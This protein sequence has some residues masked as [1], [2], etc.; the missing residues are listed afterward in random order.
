VKREV[1]RKRKTLEKVLTMGEGSNEK[2]ER[3]R[4]MAMTES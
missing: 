1:M 3:E 4:E 2:E